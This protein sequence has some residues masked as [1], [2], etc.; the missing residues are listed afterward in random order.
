MQPE[1]FNGR[2]GVIGAGAL[3]A[4]YGARMARA[5][6]D[7]RFLLRSDYDAVQQDGLSI[8]SFQGDFVLRPPI[9]RTAEELG[10]CDLL[11]VGLKATDTEAL[12]E[13]LPHVATPTTAVLTL[14]NGLGNEERIAAMLG[15]LHPDLPAESRIVGGIAFLCSNRVA[16][17]V[18]HH[19][20]YG[21]V[22]LAEFS[23]AA[24]PRTR[25]LGRLF[26]DAAFECEVADSLHRIRWEKLVWNIPFN[27]LAV[28]AERADTRTLL[29]APELHATV[30]ALMFEVI[31]AAKGEG[32]EIAADFVDHMIGLSERMGP[33][34]S[35][36]QLDF[37]AGRPLEVEALLGE[38]LRRASAAGVATPLLRM[39]YGI[40]SRRER[41]AAGE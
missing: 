6:Y 33:Y 35:S 5:G 14:Q 7:V 26:T 25:T 1:R 28:A 18:I 10:P 40:V 41:L 30:R 19:I 24:T 36:M 22:R 3:G 11:L 15:A 2:I 31:A 39:L 27:G 21:H 4:L 8:R 34:K 32:V 23:G 17:G 16:P 38:P 37:E 12:R 20:E 9:A 29:D 13:I